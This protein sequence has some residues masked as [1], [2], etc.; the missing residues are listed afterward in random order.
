MTD[1]NSVP[2]IDTSKWVG[3]PNP[4]FAIGLLAGPLAT[5]VV[6]TIGPAVLKFAILKMLPASA[7]ASIDQI[8]SKGKNDTTVGQ[9]AAIIKDAAVEAVSNILGEGIAKH[10]GGVIA[11]LLAPY[12]F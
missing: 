5:W 7:E 6:K 4:E 8:T 2:A 3:T 9:V 1:P 11:R 12:F 10:V